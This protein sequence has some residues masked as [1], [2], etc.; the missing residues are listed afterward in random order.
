MVV[1]VFDQ[2]GFDGYLEMEFVD[3]TADYETAVRAE[4][5]SLSRAVP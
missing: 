3:P 5:E 2:N 1:A 4:R